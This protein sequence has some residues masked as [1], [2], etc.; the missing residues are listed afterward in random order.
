[1]YPKITIDIFNEKLVLMSYS[2]FML[3]A[4]ILGTFLYIIKMRVAGY[5]VRVIVLIIASLLISFFLGGRIFN[6]I[7]NYSAY[8]NGTLEL[9]SFSNKGFS[10]YGGIIM[11]MI[12]F[13]VICR[14]WKIDIWNLLDL[15]V[16]PFGISFF[17]MRLGCLLN[18]CCYGKNTNCIFG[19]P[20]PKALQDEIINIPDF[21]GIFDFS[22]IKVHPTQ[23]YEGVF[24]LVGSI[25]IYLFKDKFKTSG[26]I[27]LIFGIF[28]TILRLLVLPLRQLS[29]P[30]LVL[31]CLYPLFY[32]V[33]IIGCIIL[34]KRK[35]QRN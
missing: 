30:P 28:F 26:S 8:S 17:I 27:T 22:N 35:F 14:Y 21:L 13:H 31:N 16:L 34:L 23:L 20:L 12:S 11:S 25:V 33:I 4:I 7:I 3:I 6:F 18:G 9:I 10:L 29:Y 32:C 5:K 15:A 2:L 19:I 1:M 24:A